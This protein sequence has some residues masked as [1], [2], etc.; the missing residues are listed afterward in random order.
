MGVFH[1][2]QKEEKTMSYCPKCGKEIIDESKGCIYC[3]NGNT[4]DFYSNNISGNYPYFENN[5]KVLGIELKITL[6]IMVVLLAGAGPIAGIVMGII[7]MN[8][9]YKDY[10]SYGLILLITSIILFLIH[11]ICCCMFMSIGL[12]DDGYFY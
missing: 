8:K 12:Y 2:K 9:P 7:F 11:F 1:D 4:N 3:D 10:R 6:L 5:E